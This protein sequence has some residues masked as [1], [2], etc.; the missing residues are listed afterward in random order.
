MTRVGFTKVHS[1]YDEYNSSL[2]AD[3]DSHGK[4]AGG[5]PG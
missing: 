5:L 4:L 3:V 2:L 1:A